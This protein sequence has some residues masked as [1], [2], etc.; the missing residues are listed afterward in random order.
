MIQLQIS[1]RHELVQIGDES[2]LLRIAEVRDV[3]N[4]RRRGEIAPRSTSSRL[5]R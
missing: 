5:G 2:A 3:M 1:Q 4:V